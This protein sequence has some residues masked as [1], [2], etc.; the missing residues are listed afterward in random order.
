M[1]NDTFLLQLH[2]SFGGNYITR[3]KNEGKTVY[4]VQFTTLYMDR[5]NLHEQVPKGLLPYLTYIE[6]RNNYWYIEFHL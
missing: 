5:L 4:S 2:D 1:E 6:V 3:Y